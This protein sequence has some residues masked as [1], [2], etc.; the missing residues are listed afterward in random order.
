[1][2]F[3][4]NTSYSFASFHIINFLR[5]IAAKRPERLSILAECVSLMVDF[6]YLLCWKYLLW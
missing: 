2:I 4:I 3:D 1:M 5:L 6:M